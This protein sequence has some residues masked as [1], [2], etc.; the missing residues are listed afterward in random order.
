[1]AA[2]ISS[3]DQGEGKRRGA[4][5]SEKPEGKN[6]A[7]DDDCTNKRPNKYFE[8]SAAFNHVAKK[9][10]GNAAKNSTDYGRNL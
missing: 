5:T 1:M 10:A 2:P 6:H 9:V 3:I 8:P 4:F 7:G